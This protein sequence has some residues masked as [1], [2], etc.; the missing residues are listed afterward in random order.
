MLDS[1]GERYSML[2]SQVLAQGNTL[3]LWVFEVA[4]TYRNYKADE[5]NK[6]TGVDNKNIDHKALEEHFKKVKGERRNK[7]KQT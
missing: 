1:L 7:N 5:H 2:P 6:K 3:D 4:V